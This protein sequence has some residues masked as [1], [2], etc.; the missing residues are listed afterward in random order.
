[1]SLSNSSRQIF[2][3]GWNSVDVDVA[4][5]TYVGLSSPWPSR[6]DEPFLVARTSSPTVLTNIAPPAA[7]LQTEVFGLLASN[8]ISATGEAIDLANGTEHGWVPY[9]D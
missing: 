4:D 6:A 1:M 8:G 5:W 3:T 2:S 7:K 9:V